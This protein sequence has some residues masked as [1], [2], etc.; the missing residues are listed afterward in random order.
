MITAYIGFGMVWG[1][2]VFTG[3]LIHWAYTKIMED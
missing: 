1:S 2:G 3:C